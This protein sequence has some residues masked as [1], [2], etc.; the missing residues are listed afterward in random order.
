M[1]THHERLCEGMGVNPTP[2]L[3]RS[4][5]NLRSDDERRAVLRKRLAGGGVD[6]GPSLAALLRG[7][8]VEAVLRESAGGHESMSDGESLAYLLQGGSGEDLAAR[9]LGG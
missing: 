3:L 8:T 6:S 4:L 5:A 2:E 1:K 7:E 9:L